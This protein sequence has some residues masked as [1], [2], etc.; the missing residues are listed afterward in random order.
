[1]CIVIDLCFP[2]F[3]GSAAFFVVKKGISSRPALRLFAS[4]AA[5]L[6]TRP[7]TVGNLKRIGT[8]HV[9]AVG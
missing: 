1:M 4:I 7:A 8:D 3:R 2:S 5:P 9:I 6:V